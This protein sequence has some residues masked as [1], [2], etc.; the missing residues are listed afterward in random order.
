M[1]RSYL[2]KIQDAVNGSD[3][4]VVVVC[5]MLFNGAD[6]V[7]SMIFKI[8]MNRHL[9][10]LVANASNLSY[11]D[12]TEFLLADL[13]HLGSTD[14]FCAHHPF[15][16]LGVTL[17]RWRCEVGR[18]VENIIGELDFSTCPSYAQELDLLQI[19]EHSFLGGVIEDALR[20]RLHV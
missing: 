1:S 2:S 12:Y 5:G 13:W 10:D 15:V 6:D 9:K 16:Y 14:I 17:F 4:P 11:F 19:I 20:C 3:V 7:A 18:F 8:E